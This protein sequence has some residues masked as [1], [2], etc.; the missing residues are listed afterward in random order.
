MHK[1]G[2]NEEEHTKKQLRAFMH[3]TREPLIHAQ[4]VTPYHHASQIRSRPILTKCYHMYATIYSR[5]YGL[6][7]L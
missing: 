2:E 4:L 6:G 3:P 5:D 1:Q 7:G